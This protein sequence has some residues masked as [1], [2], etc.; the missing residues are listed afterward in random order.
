MLYQNLCPTCGGELQKVSATQYACEFCGNTYATEKIEDY[1]D[2]LS[3][4]FDSSKLEMVANAKRSLYAAIAVDYISKIEVIKWCDEIKKYIPD[5][6]QANFY[7][8]LAKESKREVAKMLRKID[9]DE[10][11]DILERLITIV[12]NSLEKSYIAPV[13]DLIERAYYGPDVQKYHKYITMAEG[14]AEKLDSCI[15]DLLSQRDVFVAYSSKDRDKVLELVEYLEN[16]G[17][18]CF[19]SLRN[20]RHGVGSCENY[21]KALQTAMDNCTSFVFVSSM[22]SRNTDCDAYKI[23]IPYVIQQDKANAPGNLR[24]NY[25]KIPNEYKKP[26]VE[27]YIGDSAFNTLADRTVEGFFGGYERVYTANDVAIRIMQQTMGLDDLSL[28]S[29]DTQETQTIVEKKVKY[30][31]AC[32]TECSFDAKFCQACGKTEFAETK[33]EA[34]LIKKLNE[35]QGQLMAKPVSVL[36]AE[37][38]YKLGGDYYYGRNNKNQDYAEAVKH[39]KIAAEQGH[40]AAQCWFGFCYEKGHG[41][42]QSWTEAVKW[43]KLAAG[44]CEMY[45][46][47][48]LG[49]CYYYGNGVTKDY[50]E[51]VK[52]YKLAAEQ[53]LANAQNALGNRYYNGEGVTKDYTEAVKWYRLAAE[54]GH[55]SAQ[56]ALGNRYYN[57]EGVTKDYTE[58]VKWYRLAAE[59][60][61]M[62]AQYNLGNCHYYGNGVAKDYYEAAKWY[63]LAAEQGHAKAQNALGNRYYNGEGVTKDYTEAVKWY[64]LAA[65]QGEMYG[66]YNLGICYYYGNG[67]TKNITESLKWYKLAADQ[68]HENAQKQYDKLKG[69]I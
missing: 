28:F 56:N 33:K 32:L 3:K 21:N 45:A 53:G 42:T 58:A 46:Q 22:N 25:A 7:Y 9:V 55:A 64:R 34:E 59:Q 37:E 60:G 27:Y 26:R 20:L 69:T 11:C 51:A 43:Y 52:W 39:Y 12:I 65:E 2:K 10:H 40:A 15:Y 38:E 62:Y 49:N 5:D 54:Q 14:E 17:L 30:C 67:V 47:N 1:A 13:K 16:E 24:N 57:G 61:E 48:N 29:D 36:S 6:F 41:V 50:Y 44:Q 68:G 18:T 31:V 4:L 66:Q 35:L 23:E 8:A 19:I 63:R